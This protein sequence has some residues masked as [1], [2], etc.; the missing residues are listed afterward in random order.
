MRETGV[1]IYPELDLNKQQE[2]LTWAYQELMKYLCR[3]YRLPLMEWVTSLL[4]I[5]PTFVMLI[6][7]A[8]FTALHILICNHQSQVRLS[9]VLS[10]KQK[11]DVNCN[12]YSFA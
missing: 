6:I 5:C 4:H 3:L 9:Y 12:L 10:E 8:E 1:I 11:N 2:C 7:V